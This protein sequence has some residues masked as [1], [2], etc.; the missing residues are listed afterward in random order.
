MFKLRTL[1]A[2][3][4]LGLT[5]PACII[6]TGGGDDDAADTDEPADSGDTGMVDTG[7]MDPGDSDE[8]ID[9]TGDPMEESTGGDG[10]GF[11]FDETPPEDMVQADRM[12]M[13]AINTAVI[14]SKDEY[15]GAGPAD[16]IAGTY[17]DEIVAN[18][19]GLHDALDDDLTGAGLVP[20]ATMDCVNQAAPLVV[21]D[22][23]S[24]DPAA[25]AGFP[26]GRTP[27]DPVIDVTLAVV[28]LDLTAEGQDAATL[29]GLPLNPPANDVEFLADFPYL[30]AP[31]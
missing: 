2:L 1:M 20:C 28:L 3:S 11:M 13:P 4:V 25:A 12:G 31:N 15:N 29:A 18:V 8:G 16:D 27:A 7:N 24:I 21:P 14:S 6:N 19:Q 26:N 23:L 22:V 30:A 5:L 10:G 17:V 9:S